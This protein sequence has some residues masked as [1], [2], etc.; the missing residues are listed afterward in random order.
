M[1]AESRRLPPFPDEL[2]E[3]RDLQGAINFLRSLQLPP[4]YARA[5]LRRFSLAAKVRAHRSD[6]AMLGGHTERLERV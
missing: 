1:N 5:H 3:R 6:Y 2:V 4:E